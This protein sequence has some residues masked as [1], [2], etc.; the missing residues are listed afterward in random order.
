[1]D[2]SMMEVYALICS[3]FFLLVNCNCLLTLKEKN[4]GKFWPKLAKKDW[5]WVIKTDY[6]TYPDFIWGV[7]IQQH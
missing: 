2:F 1:M 6:A 3:V 7:A 4:Q 5:D